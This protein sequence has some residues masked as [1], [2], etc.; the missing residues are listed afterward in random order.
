M[1]LNEIR[2]KGISREIAEVVLKEY[3]D[4]ELWLEKAR[5]TLIQVR[6]KFNNRQVQTHILWNKL[7][8]RG[9]S[10]EI[11]EQVIA[12]EGEAD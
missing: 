5:K 9:F 4:D 7:Y 12:E 8:Q 3:A 1:L 10:K 6:R 2:A 11:I